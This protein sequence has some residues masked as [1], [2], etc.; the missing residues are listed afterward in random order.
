MLRRRILQI[1]EECQRMEPA[2]EIYFGVTDEE[3]FF[4]YTLHER[5]ILFRGRIDFPSR[6]NRTAT[7]LLFRA[8]Q[9]KQALLG[10]RRALTVRFF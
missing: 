10:Y 2:A 6:S 5:S 7:P 8:G 9:K 3:F 4:E 1:V